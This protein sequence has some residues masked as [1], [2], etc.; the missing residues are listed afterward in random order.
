MFYLFEGLVF[1]SVLVSILSLFFLLSSPVIEKEI[2]FLEL[3]NTKAHLQNKLQESELLQLSRQI[4]PHFMFNTLNVILSLAR[5]D[6]KNILVESIESFSK[7]LRYK[8]TDKKDLIPFHEE[9]DQ[10]KNYFYIQ[11]LRFGKKLQISVQVEQ[12]EL[13]TGIPPYTLQILVENAFKHALEEK[14]GVMKL[15]IILQRIGNWVELRV[16]DNGDKQLDLQ[17]EHG[18]GLENIRKRLNLIFDLFTEVSITR[19]KDEETVARVI[20]PYMIVED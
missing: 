1:T 12:S 8:Y 13:T 4:Q 19:I 2:N 18:I 6:R 11:K 3:E 15:T 7:Y 10:V 9:L 14:E 16:I 20:W 17:A 5:L